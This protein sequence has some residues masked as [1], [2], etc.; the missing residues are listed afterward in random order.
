[1][2]MSISIFARLFSQLESEKGDELNVT[3]ASKTW[4]TLVIAT[5]FMVVEYVHTKYSTLHTTT[6]ILGDASG[7]RAVRTAIVHTPDSAASA[8]DASTL[9]PQPRTERDSCHMR[10]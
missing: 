9:K 2:P 1:M 10:E 7:L 5:L 6:E 4:T 3:T 8:G